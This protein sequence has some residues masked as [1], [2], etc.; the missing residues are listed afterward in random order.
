MTIQNRRFILFLIPV[1][2]ALLLLRSTP[3][4]AQR[5][6]EQ[7]GRGIMAMN[8]G[9][10]QIYVG[11]RLLGTDPSDITFNLYQSVNNA[12][13]VKVNAYPM[14]LTTDTVLSGC[15]L[16]VS[17]AFFVKPVL[18]G[19]EQTSSSI[20]TLPANAAAVQYV[21]SIPL[22]NLNDANI[23]TQNAMPGDV[24]GDGEYELVVFRTGAGGDTARLLIETYKLNGT[25]LWRF[26]FGKNIN[27]S[28]EHNA[29]AYYVVYDFDGDGKAEVCVRGSELSTFQS[30][31]AKQRTVGDVLLK[32]GV[33]LY[34]LNGGNQR[35]TAPEYLFML[36]G[37]TGAPMDSIKYEPAMGSTPNTTW[38]SNERPVYQWMSVAYLDGIHPSIV[39]ERGIGEGFWIKLYGFDFRNGKFSMRPEFFATQEPI[40]FGGHS[41]RTKD[42]DNDGKDEILFTAAAVDHDMKLIY[43]Q[44]YKGL[45]HGDGFQILDIDPDRPG[46]EWFGIQQS[47]SDQLGAAYWDAATGEVI[48]KYYMAA[49]GDPSRGDAASVS[50]TIRG[51][52]MY[53]G[54][55]GVMDHNGN[56]VNRTSFTPTGTLYWDADLA[57]EVILNDNSY[58]D[59]SIKKYD[60]VTGNS[61]I[62]FNLKADGCSNPATMAGATYFGDILGDWRE[63]LAIQ[64][65]DKLTLRIYSTTTPSASRYYTLMHNG[66]YRIQQTCLGRI[67]GFYSDFYFGPGMTVMPPCP[68]VGEDVRWAGSLA[69]WDNGTTQAWF[70]STGL[71]AFQPAM[72]V[73]FD[74][75]G[76]TGTVSQRTVSIAEN[77]APAAVTVSS[78]LSYEFTG[79]GTITGS[80]TLTK[81]GKG[82]LTLNNNLLST[83]KTTV[84]DGA[85]IARKSLASPVWVYGGTWGGVRSKGLTGGRLAGVGPFLQGVTLFEKGGLSPG[86]SSNE[87]D[88][89]TIEQ[90]LTLKKRSY[91]VLDLNATPTL[92]SDFILVKGDLI[93]E[94]TASLYVRKVASTLGAG[95]YPL[96]KCTGT[97]TGNV[98]QLLLVGMDDQVCSLSISDNTLFLNVP[99]V[100]TAS[101]ATWGGVSN[102][103]ELSLTKNWL[104]NSVA[105]LFVPN[106][107]VVFDATGAAQSNV[108]LNGVIP[109][110]DLMVNATNDYTLGG[111]GSLSGSGGLTKKGRGKLTLPTNHS[112]TGKVSVQGGSLEIKDDVLEG[113]P[114]PIGLGPVTSVMDLANAQLRF[115]PTFPIGFDRGIALT[116]ADTIYASQSATLEGLVSGTGSVVKLGTGKINF[117]QTNTY[118]GGTILKEGTVSSSQNNNPLGT[119]LITFAG[120]RLTLC[121]NNND[122]E[123]F[124]AP[125]QIPAGV[126]ALL[127]MD[128]R[129]NFA[130][131]VTGSGTL[132]LWTPYV[133]ADLSG[134]W[135]AFTGTIN[136]TTDADGGDF[137]VNNAYGFAGASVNLA[138]LVYAYRNSAQTLE[139]GD[140]SGVAG[141]VVSNTPL[142]V[143][144]KNTNATFNGILTGTS[145]ITKRG[146]GSWT[147]TGASTH[148][149]NTAVNGGKLIVN[150]TTGSGTGTGS[151]TVN[152]TGTLSGT[153]IIT[154]AV[155]VNTGGTLAPGNNAIGTLTVNSNVSL[156]VGST[157][158]MEINR[159]SATK[160][161][162]TLTGTLTLNGTLKLVN[163]SVLGYS[164][165]NEFKLFTA[166]TIK[167]AFSAI[168]PATPGDGLVWDT[169]ALLTTGTIAVRTAP[170]ALH[171]AEWA[172]MKVFPNPTA[173][174]VYL[175]N[176]PSIGP[177]TLLLETLNGK[178]LIQRKQVSS[179]TEIDLSEYSAG[180]Y[181]LKLISDQDTYLFKILKK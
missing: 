160:D 72:K 53:G 119:G 180:M 70:D 129:I 174:K 74:S 93:L 32:D 169:T 1:V 76:K 178:T 176:I 157:T 132:N 68:L 22:Q 81:I 23:T 167:G 52:Q 96:L 40:A 108:Q 45:G 172:S 50:P 87:T 6:M 83:G 8:K 133:R 147:L 150:N 101:K 5:Q 158:E 139:L 145:S 155:A 16:S 114:S 88:T 159:L 123:T 34:P 94:D 110:R 18:N 116:G 152:S 21:L 58:R 4:Q 75:Y 49:V 57:K 41:I 120:G 98:G 90:R 37:K 67:G 91:L 97:L 181:L 161:M 63:E 24:D 31:S 134:N 179:E 55:P 143:G 122:T 36:N 154:G 100:P 13:A 43:N 14:K 111:T 124:S 33:T 137:R 11:W 151:V 173:G 118:S 12:T 95:V 142:V 82:N 77:V 140:L 7:L 136:V 153:G 128:S 30:G 125:I 107:S 109:V 42:I 177:V 66:G 54:T 117:S 121:D 73:L 9:S 61:N 3:M 92:T 127:D 141:S 62:L 84:W 38:G 103:W 15:N 163:L 113:E 102:K 126:T 80:G 39:T 170:T 59:A 156:G 130:S 46:L 27:F 135:S 48:K 47:N 20:F 171:D 166:P 149:G 56:Y 28:N 2:V 78:E 104:R 144:A 44:H 175:N 164:N 86:S 105:D 71:K 60:P 35:L 85:L 64:T 65:N 168:L 165:G 69:T 131:N 162:L 17:N 51:S 89:M 99:T 79:A 29:Q 106:D 25:F 10:N 138:N 146:T 148:T 112:F 19:V 26:D 115:T